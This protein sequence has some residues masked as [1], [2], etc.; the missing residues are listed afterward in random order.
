MKISESFLLWLRVGIFLLILSAGVSVLYA[1]D[2]DVSRL[3]SESQ[4]VPGWAFVLAM[5]LLPVAGFPIAAFYLFA[6]L[7]YGFW[8]G[9]I[10]C[11]ISLA[12]NMSLSYVVARYCLDK[13][14]RTFLASRGYELPQ[15]SEV[16]QFRFTF[17]LRTVPGPPYPVQNYLLS[18]MG[19][20]FA[21][22]LGL[23]LLTQGTIA[24]GMVACGGVLPKEIKMGHVLVGLG[25]VLILLL[26]R[27]FL[28][29]RK[30]KQ[31]A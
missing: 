24:A 13:P 7:A 30:R 31:A 9:W 23:S 19:I 27:L 16:N 1:L 28:W 8:E 14:L 29:W 17:I 20:P 25:L 21:L 18:L 5:S 11:L 2:F 26:S 22:Y 12:I 10:Y 3:F 15:L 4:S 6:G